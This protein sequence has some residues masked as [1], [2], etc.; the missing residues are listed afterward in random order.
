[1]WA[2]PPMLLVD[3]TPPSAQE[4]GTA[5]MGGE[6]GLGVQWEEGGGGGGGVME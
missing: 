2:A 3:L 5:V 6:E 1:M 4:S